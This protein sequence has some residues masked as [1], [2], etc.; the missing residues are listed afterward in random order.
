M[1]VLLQTSTRANGKACLP[2]G[3]TP[4]PFPLSTDGTCGDQFYKIRCSAATSTL[5]LDTVN[6]SYP[7]ISISPSS[8]RLV[9]SPSSLRNESCISSDLSSQGIQLGET[10][11]FNVTSRNTIML[12]NCTSKILEASLNCSSNSLC[13]LLPHSSCQTLPICC[14]F[15]AGGSAS[16]HMIHITPE[17][18]SAYRSY[19]DLDPTKP[20][21]TWQ[22]QEGVE[23]QW[24]SPREPMCNAQ[25][26]CEDGATTNCT[27]DPASEGSLVKRRFCL[28][29]TVWN[30]I[31]G[32]CEKN[33]TDCNSDNCGGFDSGSLIAGKIY[34][35]INNTFIL[36][37]LVSIPS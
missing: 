7:I 2:C 32:T 36:Q 9:I 1:S 18:C 33:Q 5:F 3:T 17:Y 25:S 6:S 12:L 11:P 34:N 21:V 22:S 26:D 35:L 14:T 8:Q 10:P 13:H 31:S 28:S 37:F 4:V 27:V 16:S 15:K 19:I 23:L 24:V 30:P 20:A 29:P